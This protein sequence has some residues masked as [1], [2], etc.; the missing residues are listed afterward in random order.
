MQPAIEVHTLG[1]RYN[2]RLTRKNTLRESFKNMARRHR[3][4]THFWA[5]RD[6]SFQVDRGESLAIIGPNGA[7]K[8]TLLQVLAGILEPTE[9]AIEVRGRISS[10]LTLGAGFDMELSGHDNIVLAGAFMG[11]DHRDMATRLPEII[12]FADLGQFIDAPIKTYSAGMNARLGFSIATA[13]EPDVL[14]LDEVLGTGDAT[15]RAKSQQRVMELMRAAR[16]IVLVTHDM[17]W[18]REFCNRAILLEQGNVVAAGDPG[19]VVAIHEDRSGQRRAGLQPQPLPPV[20]DSG[21][22]GVPVAAMVAQT[23]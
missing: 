3:G 23:R 19:E 15:F 2:L 8:S 1:V 12:D 21:L 4:P 11:L 10:L 7:G 22:G 5:L 14:L 6:V 20:V 17:N 13:V 18:A 16:A 9:G